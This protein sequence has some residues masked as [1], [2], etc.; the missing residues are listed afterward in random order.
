[1]ES[2]LMTAIVVEIDKTS[3]CILIRR[4]N[5]TEQLQINEK[6][7]I[8]YWVRTRSGQVLKGMNA[9]GLANILGQ[10]ASIDEAA[11]LEIVSEVDAIAELDLA[12]TTAAISQDESVKY[13]VG[14]F[15][16]AEGPWL[17]FNGFMATKTVKNSNFT[18][19]KK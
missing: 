10:L 19:W 3:A 17:D 9:D 13:A 5:G 8:V 12:P 1:M 11:A 15:E 18:G 2:Y 14:Y 16:D 7:H 6:P 4:P